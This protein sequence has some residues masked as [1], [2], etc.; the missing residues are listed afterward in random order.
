MNLLSNRPK[1]GLAL[2]GG[3]PK[4]LAHIGIIKVLEE[5]NIPIDYIAGTSIG[6]MVGGFYAAK[7]NIYEIE[8]LA[9][10]TNWPKFISIFFD[11]SIR[12]GLI[13]G[14]KLKKFIEDYLGEIN[15]K[16]LKIPFKAVATDLHTGE[17]FVIGKDKV[18]TA[19]KASTAIPLM[20]TPVKIDNRTLIDG[21]VSYPVPVDVVRQMGA[22][23]VIAVNLTGNDQFDDKE[24]KLTYSSIASNSL[25]IL[26]YNLALENIKTAEFV[27]AP[28]VG[29][30]GWK[31]FFTYKG[32]EKSIK[33]GVDALEP[34]I[35]E[36]KEIINK[37]SQNNNI[38][39]RLSKIF[40]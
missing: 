18:S 19:I 20:F 32:T 16:D 39:Q 17:K 10:T 37:R 8:K 6:A 2:G 30:I 24:K 7:K 5:N 40:K 25:N 4:G 31:H 26:R 13:K 36:L 14:E 11:P 3:G 12:Q 21:G 1:I 23:F 22:D 15:F 28:K 38:F 9:L 35:N 34:R 29:D 27:I 33:L